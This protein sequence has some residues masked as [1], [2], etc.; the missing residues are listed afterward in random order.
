[1]YVAAFASEFFEKLV[2]Y[3]PPFLF[4]LTIVVF[5]HELGHYLV[6]RWC[7]VGIDT[8]SIGFGKEIFGWNDR[9]GTRWRLA[10][11]PLGGY[12][13]FRGDAN[14]ASIPD[15]DAI[16]RMNP[17]ERRWSFVAKPV[18]QRASVVAAGPIANFLLAIV[19]FTAVFMIYGR[20]V[21][22][23]I[24]SGV[25]AGSAAEQAGIRAG[26][27]ILSVNKD[28]ISSFESLQR[29]VSVSSGETLILGI[30]RAGKEISI[31]AVPE[32]KEISTIFG[33]HRQGLLGIEATRDSA[34]VRIETYGFGDSVQRAAAETW[35]V[36]ERT[37]GF[38][39][40]L[41]LGRESLDQLSGPTRI[42]QVSGE[43]AKV[44]IG[45]L[46]SLAAL[47]SISIGLIN[48][49]P[50]P[51]LDGGHLLF[52]AYEA[53][54]GRPLSEK[55]QDIGYRI[56]LALVLGLMVLATWN[57]LSHLWSLRAG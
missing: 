34:H 17:E 1:M 11:I 45:A 3:G 27:R 42:A 30:E 52:Y 43:V 12:V 55:L 51:M 50:I 38:I 13:K 4:V 5:F 10:M 48:L 14:G 9:H 15:R 23:P 47:L 7:G 22:E 29:I 18:W 25:R 37:F 21:Q 26:D 19:I 2:T 24:V 44:G 31:P 49:F 46:L 57:D 40:G 53:V 56:G 16:A 35:F 41:F 28:P 8:F 39:H 6:A 36:V 20:V 33:K 32:W 54:F